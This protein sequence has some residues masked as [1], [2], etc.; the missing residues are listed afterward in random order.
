[1]ERMVIKHTSGS[2]ANQVEEFP[3]N[4]Y[5][6]LILG[7][8]TGSTVQ[9]DPDRD[10]LVGRQHA[11][12]S[13]DKADE[14]AFILEDTGSRNGT[15]LNGVRISEPRKIQPGDRVQLGTGGPEFTFDVEP[16]PAGATK[17]TRIAD[18]A[19]SS[20]PAT[21]IADSTSVVTAAAA[22]G[23]KPSVGKATVERMIGSSVAETK[24]EQGRK[25][26][27]IG[28]VAAVLVLLLFGAVIAGGYWYTSRQQGALQAEIANKSQ[29]LETQASELKNKMDQSGLTAAEITA[30]NEG[31]VVY[32]QSSW[33]LLNKDTKAQIYHQFYPNSREVLSK[34]L[35]KDFGKGPIIPNGGNAIPIYFRTERGI[36]PMLTDKENDL[37][38]PIGYGS[39]SCSGFIVTT[40]GFILTNKHCTSP[41]KAPYDFGDKY[42]QGILL[43]PDLQIL[44]AGVDPPADWIPDNHRPSSSAQYQGEFDAT[45]KITVMLKGSDTPIE[46]TKIQDSP[47]HDV[48]MLKISVPGTLPKVELYDASETLKKGDGLVIMGYPGSAPRVYAPIASQN[49][50]DRETKFTEIPDPTTSVTSVGNI[51]KNSDP[52]DLN[53]VRHSGAGDSIRYPGSLTYGGNSGGPVFDM[54]GRV[55]GLHYL[56]SGVEAGNIVGYAVPIKYGLQLFPGGAPN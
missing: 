38:Q 19:T 35:K 2:K 37:S 36:E 23:G 48:G 45:Q 9:Y 12:I 27:A 39:G 47:R 43:S 15:Y 14:N 51:L 16:R 54:Q 46:A 5:S 22:G 11:K 4:H 52:N 21:R 24:R 50:K 20:T 40:D 41:W 1:M 6:E 49:P 8:E 53:N 31:A 10:D 28:A 42:P 26:G 56:G 44:G 18:V 3:L 33:R 25:Y 13:R 30:K 32:L 7:R 55:I 34:D 29:Q 17:A